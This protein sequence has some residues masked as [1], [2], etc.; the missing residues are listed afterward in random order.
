MKPTSN[1]CDPL[2]GTEVNA[3]LKKKGVQ[4]P[5]KGLPD[6]ITTDVQQT[7]IAFKIGDIM[8]VL[9]L[10]LEDDSLK[11]TPKR[12]ANMFVNELYWGLSD[13]YFPRAMTVENKMSYDE[14]IVIK[15][16]TSMSA[17]EHHF[18]TIDGKCSIAYIPNKKVLGL[19]KINR[20]VEYFSRRPQIQERLTEQIFYALEYILETSN[21]AVVME[22]VHYCVKS[23]GVEDTS[24]STMTSKLGGRFKTDT[25]MRSEFMT[26]I[27]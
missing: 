8:A 25:A 18:V 4:T 1:K 9:G 10:D 26:L 2:L 3:Y 17:C 21:I 19:S 23:R 16:V 24:S 20:I 6:E 12:I 13:D 14:M 15:D 5:M 11:G 7:N 22:G 27:K